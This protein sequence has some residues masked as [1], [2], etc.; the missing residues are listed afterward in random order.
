[1]P[2][3]ALARLPSI[4]AGRCG[5]GRAAT[6]V[7]SGR[8]LFLFSRCQGLFCPNN[9]KSAVLPGHIPFSYLRSFSSLRACLV[10]RGPAWCVRGRGGRPLKHGGEAGTPSFF[11]GVASLRRGGARRTAAGW[12]APSRRLYQLPLSPE[13]PLAAVLPRCALR[14]HIHDHFRAGT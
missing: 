4:L 5:G 6:P 12:R 3:L 11:L 10:P 2:P 7:P 13:R 14:R 9:G 1:M 8:L